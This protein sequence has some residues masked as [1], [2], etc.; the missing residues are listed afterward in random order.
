MTGEQTAADSPTRA[1]FDRISERYDQIAEAWEHASR[2][3]GVEALAVAQGEAVLEIGF[4]TGRALEQFA[5]AGAKVVGIDLSD[6]MRSVARQRL[7][8]A[9]LDRHV[10]LDLGDARALPYA[11]GRFD[12]AFMS[13]TIE[14]F[15]REDVAMVLAEA[16]RVLRAGGRLGIVAMAE[17]DPPELATEIYRQLQARFPHFADCRP[18]DVVG[19]LRAAGFR[20][21]ETTGM[22]SQ[23]LPVLSVIAIK[24]D[25]AWY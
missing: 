16:S 3:Q 12:A 7:V 22:S 24:P 13:F 11:E 18:V 9:G 17:K 4:G 5:G 19:S 6:G 1:F 23:R 2:R 10:R 20:I 21:R 15:D 8:A 25:G 14:L